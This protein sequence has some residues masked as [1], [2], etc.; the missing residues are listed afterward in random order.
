MMDWFSTKSAPLVV[1]FT[2]YDK[3]L[4]TKKG[5]LQEDN[6]GMKPKVLDEWSKMG[7]QEVLDICVQSLERTM[8]GM[9]TPMPR[10]VNVSSIISHSLFDRC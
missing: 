8:S 4:R 7:A 3:L 9:N 10:Y 5:E 2:K 1:V 6:P